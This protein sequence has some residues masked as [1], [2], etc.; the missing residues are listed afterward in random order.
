MSP[1]L[2]IRDATLDDAAVIA[3]AGIRSGDQVIVGRR[4]W[5]SRNFSSVVGIVSIISNVILITTR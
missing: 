1:N 3:E 2:I 4:A 5:F